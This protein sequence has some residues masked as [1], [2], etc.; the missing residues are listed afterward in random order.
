MEASVL[1]DM[2][3]IQG[4]YVNPDAIL[5]AFLVRRW[6]LDEL[7]LRFKG[8]ERLNRSFDALNH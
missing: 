5:H 6:R 7:Q 3:N 8:D 4:C 1:P 2:R